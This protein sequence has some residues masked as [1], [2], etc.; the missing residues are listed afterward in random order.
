MM[1]CESLQWPEE[2]C[3]QDHMMA[4]LVCGSVISLVLACLKGL[5]RGLDM[6]IQ[7]NAMSTGG[8]AQK[9]G[10]NLQILGCRAPP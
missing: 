8:K 6:R 1:P 9:I 2:R 10:I 4:A 7:L 3:F 5:R